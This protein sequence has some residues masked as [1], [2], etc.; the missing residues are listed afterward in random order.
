MNRECLLTIGLACLSGV[1]A[2]ICQAQERPNVL[3]ISIDDL[4][5]WVGF[6]GGHPQVRTPYMDRL[7][8]RGVVFSNAHCAAPRCSPSRASVLSGKQPFNSG[9]YDN[10]DSIAK[11]APELVLLPQHFQANG[12]RAFGTGKILHRN[13]PDLFDEYFFPGQR[14]SPFG[15]SAVDYTEEELPSKSTDDPR[16]VID[17]GPGLAPVVLPLSR[18]RSVRQP[19]EVAADSF[20]WGGVDF[21]EGEFGDTKVA[22]WVADQLSE[23]HEQPFFMA[24]GFY[25]PH[26]PLYAPRR[27]FDLYPPASVEL[28]PNLATDLDDLSDAGRLATLQSR[29]VELHDHVV[30][31]D[32]WHD[33]VAA[34]LA[35]I[36]FADEQLGRVL[37]ALEKGPHA[38]NTIVVLWGDHGFHLGEKNHWGKWTSWERSTRVPLV[39]VPPRNASVDFFT[40]TCRQP[41]GLID[42]YP[43]MIE[44]T[45]IATRDDLDGASLV[46]LL[47]DPLQHRDTPVITTL[48]PGWHTLRT[49]RWRWMTYVDGTEELYD[50]WADPNEWQNLAGDAEYAEVGA[51]MRAC[52]AAEGSS[53]ISLGCVPPAA[54]G[55]AALDD[56]FSVPAGGEVVVLP[57]LRNDNGSDPAAVPVIVGVTRPARGSVE[58]A[59]GGSML[60][61]TPSRT[62]G[63]TDFQYTMEVDG[64]E[65]TAAVRVVFYHDATVGA[66]QQSPVGLV[67][68]ETESFTSSVPR[69]GY[70]WTVMPAADFSGEA[71]LQVLPNDGQSWNRGQ[72]VGSSPRLDFL[73]EFERTGVHYVWLRGLAPTLQSNSV[74]VGLDGFQSLDSSYYSLAPVETF[75]WLNA[76]AEGSRAAIEVPT[77]GAHHVNIWAREVG[78]IIDKIIVTSDPD[79]VPVDDGPPQSPRVTAPP[80]LPLFKRGD[81]NGDG[82]VGGTVS[83][84]VFLVSFLFQG[85]EQ[86]ECLAACDPDGDG[87]VVGQV[88][89]AVFLL[90]FSF[91]GGVPPPPPFP[92]CGEGTRA[93]EA[94]GCD[95]SSCDR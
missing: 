61:F 50:L 8:S 73:V 44:M 60:L 81:C 1:A 77:V 12:Y 46:P 6:L 47:K 14:W 53:G 88:T 24:V 34:Y 83:D 78:T 48:G 40:G 63:E 35:C 9:V 26:V 4:N 55:A 95:Q 76:T 38:D 36:T 2:P 93:D 64:T 37:Y 33:V 41:V 11:I 30:A 54:A 39:I 15:S 16:H 67:S 22:A 10:P 90:N 71:S 91:Q 72:H 56:A 74:F 58:V 25:R 69:S 3:F 52:L 94:L 66:Y 92:L 18:L 23:D 19:E 28:P 59:P 45:D 87:E 70:E 27:Y 17:L 31:N 62:P 89:D 65:H 75:A 43:T 32:R 57:V 82:E 29:G 21:L 5:D 7:A 42:L 20:D 86:P 85:A 49:H 68:M 79:F 51:G 13:R 84:V 80:N